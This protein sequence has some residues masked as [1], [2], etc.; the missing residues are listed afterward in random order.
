MPGVGVTTGGGVTTTVGV[1]SGVGVTS[2]V[3]VTSGVAVAV[4]VGV[5]VGV[6]VAVGVIVGDGVGVTGGGCGGAVILFSPFWGRTL[7]IAAGG[8]AQSLKVTTCTS[9]VV[10]APALPTARQVMSARGMLA[11]VTPWASA[12]VTRTYRPNQGSCCA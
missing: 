8:S 5:G 6:G 12:A 11:P 9:R 7:G 1:T 3:G 4:T 10:L 2:T